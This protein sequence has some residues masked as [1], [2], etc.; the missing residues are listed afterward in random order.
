MTDRQNDVLFPL[1]AQVTQAGVSRRNVLRSLMAAGIIGTLVGRDAEAQTASRTVTFDHG[2]TSGDPLADRIILWTRATSAQGGDFY[3]TWELASD[4]NITQIVASGVALSLAARDNT[5]KVDVTGLRPGSTYFYRFSF[6][7]T[8]STVGRTK[9]LPEG[10]VSN[11]KLAVFSCATLQKGYFNV[12]AEAATRDDLDAVL[13]LGDYIYEYGPGGYVTP[14][15]A[16]GVVREVRAAELQPQKEI[17]TLA[18]YRTRHANYRSDR[19]LQALAAKAPWIV[20]WDDHESANDSYRAG[21]DNHT[22]GKEGTWTDRRDAALRAYFEWMPVREPLFAA[23]TG[24]TVSRLYRAFDYGNLLRLVMLDT[25]LTARDKQI[26]NPTQFIGLYQTATAEG[27]FPADVNTDGTQRQL[28]GT[29]QE[30]WLSDRLKTSQQTW[31]VIGQQILYQWQPAPDLANTKLLTDAQKAQINAL[32]DQIF[33]AGAAQQFAA[34]AAL[35]G[36]NPE[37]SDSWVGYPSARARFARTLLQAKNPVI[38]AGDT[39]NAWA[40]DLRLPTPNG[41][42]PIGVEV[43]TPGVTSP[44]YEEIFVGVPPAAVAGIIQESGARNQ[45]N[46]QLVYADTSQRGY[47]LVDITHDRVAIEWTYVSTVFSPAYRASMQKRLEVKPGQKKFSAT[48]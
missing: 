36:P 31:Q 2:V 7:S 14:A 13:H 21:A 39:H 37:T 17:V 46:D 43:G 12:Y 3:V 18:D 27:R 9:T 32:I 45:S 5:V 30:A 47:M 33:G 24:E 42:I 25:R 16:A 11:V 28:L 19:N 8:L 4:A 35:G 48:V 15:L 6:G 34:V 38:L 26:T 29:T 1:F 40:A 44:G 10:A 20:V 22:E 23:G 41:V